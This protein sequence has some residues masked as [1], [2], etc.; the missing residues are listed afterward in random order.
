MKTTV[1]KLEGAVTKKEPAAMQ[2][3]LKS[4]ISSLAR[5]ASKGVIPKKRASRKISRLTVRV[6]QASATAK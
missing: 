2:A 1:K 3:A 6:N 4:A 5:T